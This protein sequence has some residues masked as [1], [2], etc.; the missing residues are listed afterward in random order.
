LILGFCASA[1][2]F[3]AVGKV[4]GP[5]EADFSHHRSNFPSEEILAQRKFSLSPTS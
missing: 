5:A 4:A 3:F 2:K 1:L